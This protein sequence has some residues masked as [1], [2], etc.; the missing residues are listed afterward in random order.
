[1]QISYAIDTHGHNDYLSGISELGQKQPVEALGLDEA[2]LG[3]SH[4][5]V[6]DGEVI[7][8]GDVA[9]EII[10]TPG[11]TPEHISL[12]VYDRSTGDEPT[13]F[14]SGGALLVGD[15]ARP[16]LLGGPD[17]A[18]A[19]AVTFCHTIQE[20]LLWSLPEHLEVWPTHVS[21][22]LCGGNIGSRLSTTLGYERKTNAILARVSS[23]EEF[24]EECI[25]LD[26]LPAV[27]PYWKRMRAQN[28]AGPPLLGVLGE[29]PAL[30]VDDFKDAMSDETVVLD[31]RSAE[32]FAAGHIKGAL[33][34]G[35]STSF[36]TWAGTV[37]PAGAC[38]L[39]VLEDP[40]DLW[41]VAWHLLR[42][43]YDVPAGWLAGGMSS[44]RTSGEDVT[45]LAQMTVHELRDA[46]AAGDVDV[47]D[48]RQP[49]EWAGGH[50]AG[51]TFVT[52][53]ELPSRVDDVPAGK[54]LAVVCGSG[55]RSSVA[56]SLLAERR[57]EPV[58][59]VLGGMSAWGV[60]GYPTEAS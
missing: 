32:A 18:S 28:M 47:L 54:P 11:H 38:V 1:M 48:V 59:N 46:L 41:E 44:W 27:P 30:R 60:A 4:R 14:L 31:C 22:S 51:A 50:I 6:K 36:P 9:F 39:L 42:T 13:L 10:H 26:N 40:G 2:E 5:P 3:Y 45:R 43:G 56:A 15:L 19:A 37:L 29:P 17:E 20:K 34:V 24:V 25:R 12:L 23:S 21:G 53:A 35:L 49:A 55:Y 8:V 33:N 16:D 52:G 58:I 57:S 7:E